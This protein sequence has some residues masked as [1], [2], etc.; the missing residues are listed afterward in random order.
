MRLLQFSINI[1]ILFVCISTAFGYGH[2]THN[3]MSDEAYNASD[4]DSYLPEMLGIAETDQFDIANISIGGMIG[5][6]LINDGT[7]R[8]WISEGSYLEDEFS[9]IDWLFRFENHYYNPINNTGLDFTVLGFYHVTGYP[10]PDWGLEDAQTFSE[11]LFSIRD[12]RDYFYNGLTA[13]TNEDRESNMALTFRTLGQ[14]IHLIQ[15]MAQPQH[16]RN[17]PHGGFFGAGWGP[18]TLGQKSRYEDYVNDEIVAIDP[19]PFIYTGYPIVLFNDY[20]SY[21]ESVDGKGLSQ[22]SNR[23]FVTHLTNFTRL[24]QGNFAPGFPEP[25]LDLNNRTEEDIQQLNPGADDFWRNLLTGVV[26]FYRN[27]ITDNYNN[28]AIND[29]L[30]TTY[31]LFDDDL[32]SRGKDPTFT[33][34]N[35]N[36]KSRANILIPRAVGYSA[37]LLD[38]FFRGELY[39]IYLVPSNDGV[40]PIMWGNQTDT[41]SDINLVSVLIQNN[42]KIDDAIEPIEEGTLA[43]TVSYKDSADTIVYV[44][45]DNTVDVTSMP[46]KGSSSYLNAIFTFT[47]PIQTQT[48]EDL[49]YHL[50]FKGQLGNEQ[51]AVIGRVIKG[52]VLHSVFPDEGLEGDEVTLTGNNLPIINGPFPTTSEDVRFQHDMTKSYTTEIVNVTTNDITAKVPNTAGLLKPGYG[53]L[54]VRHLLD[55]GE[56]IYSNPVSIFPIAQGE[57]TNTGQSTIDVTITAN[58]PIVGDNNQLPLP[59]PVTVTGLAP[60]ATAAVDLKTGYNYTAAA[61]ST[62]TQDIEILK[63]GEPDFIFNVQ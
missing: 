51:D 27:N 50:A 60:L 38:Y 24:E 33:L 2:P 55:T 30:M 40:N 17:D 20:R 9:I 11:Q 44:A 58:A 53:G 28:E 36:F 16:T 26:T 12:A 48:I 23:N 63:P 47:N 37:G 54:R 6:V 32:E 5:G 41:G 22:F 14:V 19:D 10:T 3:R 8:G 61:N 39:V 21:F 13:A 4:L 42:S 57:V 59:P 31:S 46:E 56:K 62:D 43:L 52:P 45:A 18:Q 25:T 34:N 15:D 29:V 49:T 1:L 35:F 7:P